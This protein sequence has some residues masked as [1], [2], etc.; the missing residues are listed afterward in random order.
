MRSLITDRASGDVLVDKTE[1]LTQ[2]GDWDPTIDGN[3]D[4][5]ALFGGEITAKLRPNIFVVDNIDVPVGRGPFSRRPWPFDI[6]S[7]WAGDH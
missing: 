6:G 4:L 1:D 7:A 2:F 3:F 5:E